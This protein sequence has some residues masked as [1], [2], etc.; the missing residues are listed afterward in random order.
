VTVVVLVVLA[1][2]AG[3]VMFAIRGREPRDPTGFYE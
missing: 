2:A 1:V 3:V